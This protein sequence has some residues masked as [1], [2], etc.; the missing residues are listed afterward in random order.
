MGLAEALILPGSATAVELGH[1]QVPVSSVVFPPWPLTAAEQGLLCS[2][3]LPLHSRASVEPGAHLACCS[4]KTSP[5]F[6]VP[7]PRAPS[8]TAQSPQYPLLPEPT[9][10]SSPAPSHSGCPKEVLGQPL[11]HGT[12]ASR[13][14]KVMLVRA[15]LISGL[16]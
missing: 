8:A 5:D 6:P 1:T 7:Q 2:G 13:P 9:L 16:G 12:A 3:S 11:C 4:S 14:G 15:G 10:P